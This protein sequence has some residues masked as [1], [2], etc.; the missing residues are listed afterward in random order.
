MSMKYLDIRMSYKIFLIILIMACFLALI[1]FSGYSAIKKVAVNVDTMYNNRVVPM[2]ILG[3]SRVLSK[4]V[5][6]NLLI[7]ISGRADNIER[8]YLEDSVTRDMKEFDQLLKKFQRNCPDALEQEL[9]AK[10]VTESNDYNNRIH[11]LLQIVS[12][13]EYENAYIYYTKY[14]QAQAKVIDN[15]LWQMV[16]RSQFLADKQNVE[17]QQL[18][19]QFAI[20]IL[21]LAAAACL[22]A[23]LVGIRFTKMLTHPINQ[24]VYHIEQIAGGDMNGLNGYVPLETKDE[25]GRLSRGFHRM[26]NALNAHVQEIVTANNQILEMAYQDELTH[27]PNRHFFVERLTKLFSENAKQPMA[28]LFIDLD[29]FKYINDTLGHNV[30]DSILSSVAERMKINLPEL[31]TLARLGGDEFVLL[32]RNFTCEQQVST[33]AKQV[34]AVFEQP[35]LIEGKTF[36]ITCSI[37][38]SLYPQDGHDMASILRAADTAMYDAKRRNTNSFQYYTSKMRQKVLRYMELENILYQAI[39][40]EWFQVYYQPRV[41]INSRKIVGMEALLR[42]PYQ[43]TYIS[44]AEF[45][46]VA[47]ETGLIFPIGKWVLETA[48]KQNKKWQ[49]AG[50]PPLRVSVNLSPNQ[51]NQKNLLSQIEKTLIETGLTPC[52]LELEITE[53]AFMNKAE[54][55]LKTFSAIKKLGVHISIDDFGTGYSSLGFLKRFEIDCLKIDKTFVNE[56]AHYD[57]DSSIAKA[58]IR[59]GKSLNMAIVAEG[60]E[61]QEQ[62]DF[63]RQHNCD[64]VQGYIYSPPLPSTDFELLLQGDFDLSC[65]L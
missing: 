61:K 8:T 12:V 64:Q 45:I 54:A 32:Y 13:E 59:M 60:V 51:F 29:R 25:I 41:D 40:K 20:G 18:V 46:P 37:G 14:V 28:L 7:L 48:C 55:T 27:L 53:G 49:L 9:A 11:T 56:I 50:Y 42:L 39:E 58:I 52:W 21:L 44:P 24:I 19:Q 1:G 65:C 5:E 22:I 3:Q 15:I 6:S 38:I 23:I 26:S 43:G 63:L 33:V 62:L 31:D 17:G 16:D 30:G 2:E 35:F 4:N 36:H 10:L 34:I 57:K 47:E